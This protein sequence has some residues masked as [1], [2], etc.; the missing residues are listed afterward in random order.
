MLILIACRG[1]SDETYIKKKKKTEIKP[2]V[3]DSLINQ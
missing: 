1:R 2:Y 3:L